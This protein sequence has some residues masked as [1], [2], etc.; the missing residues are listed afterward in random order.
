M[1]ATD[2]AIRTVRTFALVSLMT[3]LAGMS[4]GPPQTGAEQRAS[5]RPEA[6]TVEAGDGAMTIAWKAECPQLISGYNIYISEQPLSEDNSQPFNAAVYPGDT[7]PDDG[8]VQ[9]DA[10][11]LANGVRYYVSVRVVFPDQ[12]LS[13]PSDEVAAVCGPRGE[14]ELATRYS[15]EQDGYSFAQSRYVR[16]DDLDNDLYFYSKGG[17]D[18]LASPI[19]LDGFLRNNRFMRLS[20]D[21][22]LETAKHQLVSIDSEPRDDRVAV[23]EGDWVWIVT[24]EGHHALVQVRKLT[25]EGGKGPVALFFAYWPISGTPI[26]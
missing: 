26:L 10:Q 6:P 16:A 9:Y 13:A 22:D 3:L 2:G 24:T 18:Y 4:C 12:S 25:V 17:T 15:S 20:V 23:R 8:V 1:S 5:C 11:G 19:R 14:I 7:D 21:G